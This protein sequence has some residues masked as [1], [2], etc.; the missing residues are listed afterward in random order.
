MAR[1]K[2]IECEA[3]G[4]SVKVA[5]TGRIPRFCTDH[6]SA[7]L[8]EADDVATTGAPESSEIDLADIDMADVYDYSADELWPRQVAP[9][10][11]VGP[12]GERWTDQGD[13][14]RGM[15]EIRKQQS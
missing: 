10:V 14:E 4:K 13:A 6:T 15:A 7:D 1:P 11:W 8:P 3:C 9:T 5:A 2:S 12:K